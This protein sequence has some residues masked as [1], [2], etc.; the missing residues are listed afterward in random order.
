MLP[1]SFHKMGS[2]RRAK[3]FVKAFRPTCFAVASPLRILLS[4]AMKPPKSSSRYVQFK[5]GLCCKISQSSC[6]WCSLS[7][8]LQ[9]GSVVDASSARHNNANFRLTSASES[10]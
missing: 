8:V 9:K 3:N 6:I 2:T 1:I 10:R 4:C 7:F 5:D